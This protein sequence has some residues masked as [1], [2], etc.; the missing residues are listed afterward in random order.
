MKDGIKGR[1]FVREMQGISLSGKRNR[2]VKGIPCLITI[3]KFGVDEVKDGCIR[4]RSSRRQAKKRAWV[5]DL[6]CHI[7]DTEKYFLLES[8]HFNQRMITFM[9]AV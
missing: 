6:E 1:R 4:G 8:N 9:I 3:N 5:K 2:G 7:M